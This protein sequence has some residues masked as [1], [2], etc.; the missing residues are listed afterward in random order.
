MK[1]HYSTGWTG[2]KTPD[3]DIFRRMKT[4]RENPARDSDMSGA[5]AMLV[6]ISTLDVV[7]VSWLRKDQ[8]RFQRQDGEEREEEDNSSKKKKKK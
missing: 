8:Q 4:R 3:D 7:A 6:A 5:F 2:R 1:T